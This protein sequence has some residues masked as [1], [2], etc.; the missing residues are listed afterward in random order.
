MTAA[1]SCWDNVGIKTPNCTMVLYYGS[2]IKD[3][4]RSSGI[5]VSGK[6]NLKCDAVRRSAKIGVLGQHI[7]TQE[8]LSI[9]C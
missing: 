8:N 5:V 1:P 4:L 7:L 3:N 2:Q 9:S 6:K